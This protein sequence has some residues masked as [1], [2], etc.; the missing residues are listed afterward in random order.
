MQFLLDD[1]LCLRGGL[2]CDLV[3]PFERSALRH[4]RKQDDQPASNH[5]AS[6]RLCQRV[7]IEDVFRWEG[8]DD[9][10]ERFALEGE[11]L[12]Q[13]AREIRHAFG[14]ASRETSHLRRLVDSYGEPALPS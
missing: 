6:S 11:M 10:I 2:A 4:R 12:R 14:V 7:L 13:P 3:Q 1:F 8:G 9:C 5:Q